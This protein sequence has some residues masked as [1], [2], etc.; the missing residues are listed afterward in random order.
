MEGISIQ[1]QGKVI[2][3]PDGD[4]FLILFPDGE[5]QGAAT[6]QRAN[7][8]IKHWFRDNVRHDAI[9]VGM[10]EWRK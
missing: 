8:K 3:E 4:G 5:V 1:S 2:I 10:I 6:K 9:G 7:T